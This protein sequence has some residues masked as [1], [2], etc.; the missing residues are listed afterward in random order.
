MSGKPADVIAVRQLAERYAVA[1][2][3]HDGAMFAAQFTED[4]VLIAM[5]GDFVGRERLA[6]VPPM[7]RDIYRSTFHA[8]LNQVVDFDGDDAAGETYCIAR[9]YYDDPVG[10]TACYEM[11]IRYQ[12]RFRRVNGTWLIARRELAVDSTHRYPV[13]TPQARQRTIHGR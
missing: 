8:V 13:D 11:T 7:L 9:H 3:R 5:R 12:D 2:D 6:A 10:R 1:V 4:G